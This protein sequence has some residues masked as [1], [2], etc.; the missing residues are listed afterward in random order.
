MW[1]IAMFD[2]PTQTKED[3]RAYTR[4]R[5]KLL[6]DGFAK[7]QYSVY[8]RHCASEDNARVHTERVRVSLP[9]EGEVRVLTVTD[10]QFERMAVFW[11]KKRKPTE[12]P[13]AQLELF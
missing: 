10:K 6:K 9:P 1:V 2:L 13:A 7:M 12:A 11:G 5:K 4:F 8:M 3:R